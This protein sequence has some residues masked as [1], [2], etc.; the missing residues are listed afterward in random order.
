VAYA[1]M[2]DEIA[3]LLLAEIKAQSLETDTEMKMFD[4]VLDAPLPEDVR[5]CRL[6]GAVAAFT[7]L[8]GA[9]IPA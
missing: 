6:Q 8:I 9:E 2:A 4:I 3:S 5:M 7:K 1:K